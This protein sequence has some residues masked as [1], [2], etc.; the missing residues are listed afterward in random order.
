MVVAYRLKQGPQL[1][2]VLTPLCAVDCTTHHA[3]I[4]IR[5][6]E[7]ETEQSEPGR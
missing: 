7:E 6:W 3:A 4:G 5:L 1:G 2:V